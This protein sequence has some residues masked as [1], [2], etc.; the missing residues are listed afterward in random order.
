MLGGAWVASPQYGSASSL[1]LFALGGVVLPPP[2]GSWGAGPR[3]VQRVLCLDWKQLF[4]PLWKQGLGLIIKLSEA[5]SKATVARGVG[6]TELSS[7]TADSLSSVS[8]PCTF[9]SWAEPV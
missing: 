5:G 3:S 7:A 4:S 1:L 9:S 2:G 8:N 6:I